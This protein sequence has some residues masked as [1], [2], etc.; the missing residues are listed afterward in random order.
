MGNVP[1]VELALAPHGK[2]K[3]EISILL[4]PMAEWGTGHTKRI[5][6]F[7]NGAQSVTIEKIIKILE[8]KHGKKRK[9]L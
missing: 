3:K 7:Q 1:N 6:S 9:I 5:K 2:P 8:A 4:N